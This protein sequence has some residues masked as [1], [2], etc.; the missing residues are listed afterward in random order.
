MKKIYFSLSLLGALTFGGNMLAQGGAYWHSI[1]SQQVPSHINPRVDVL[2]ADLLKIDNYNI[3]AQLLH[4]GNTPSTGVII[5]VP[6]G[7]EL[8]TLHVWR[9]NAMAPELQAKFPEILTFTAYDPNNQAITAKLEYTTAGFSAM[10]IDPTR[11][12]Y[13][14]D[15]YGYQISEY[16]LG[17]F[18][19]DLNPAIYR[20]GVCGVKSNAMPDLL[21]EASAVIGSAP[22]DVPT[23]N[24]NAMMRSHGSNRKTY[25]LA[26]ACTG[27]WAASITGGMPSVPAVMSAIVTLVNRCNGFFQRE[28]AVKMELIPNNNSIVYIDAASD[29]YTC[30]GNNDCLINENQTN[31]DAV[32]P[33]PSTYHIGH[34]LNTAGGGLAQLNSVCDNSGK[35][36]GVSSAY[37]TSD[38]GTII[39]EMGHQ[40]GTN[41]TFN[42]GTGGC[43]GNGAESSAYEPGSGTS[44]MSY[45]GNC[46]PNNVPGPLTDYYHV[47]SLN[48]ITNHIVLGSGASCGADTAGYTP[49]SIQPLGQTYHIPKNTPFELIADS[50][51]WHEP[52]RPEVT[53]SWEQYDLGNFEGTESAASGWDAGP[54]F[55]SRSPVLKRDR[56][57]PDNALVAAN[58]YSVVGQRLPTVDRELKFKLTA[59]TFFEG[60]GTFN[61]SEDFINIKVGGSNQFRVTH[62]NATA[63][64]EVGAPIEIKWD[65]VQTRIAPILC[66]FV[67]IYMSLDGGLTFPLLVASNVENKGVYHLAAPDV[68]S[69]DIRFKVKATGNIFY[70]I[71]KTSIR[72]HGDPNSIDPTQLA[73][74]GIEVYPN[75]A[76]NVLYIRPQST[77]V[78]PIDVQIIDIAGRVVY[79]NVLKTN[80]DIPVGNFAKGNYFIQFIDNTTGKRKVEKLT[81]Q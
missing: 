52:I 66:G 35:A 38:I 50:A 54:I 51:T 41:H 36:R 28:I 71:N 40:M 65:T 63:L 62:P 23:I 2:H 8:Q 64:Y 45:N 26:V 60:W 67:N 57:F 53:Y 42:A 44:V 33:E 32:F 30:D 79:N 9:D 55:E 59:R 61:Y 72:I 49:V 27:E 34:I 20:S 12:T 75:P 77:L 10:I 21:Q 25:K 78:S 22:I 80:L 15:P 73:V 19:K 24:S 6:I 5:V 16:Y 31:L 11:G 37:S 14:I 47:A 76:T 7:K 1:S 29:P 46:A 56:Q 70:D 4:A 68:Y 43:A 39:H 69:D 81:L 3:Q 18:Q 58:T 17:Y 13:F 48:M 74:N